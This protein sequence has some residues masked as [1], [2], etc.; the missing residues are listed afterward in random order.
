MSGYSEILKMVSKWQQELTEQ[1]TDG[2][3]NDILHQLIY[4]ERVKF[5]PFLPTLFSTRHPTSYMDRLYA[6][7]T[8][9]GLTGEEQRDLLRFA[10]QIAFFSFDDF[11]VLF[12]SAFTGPISRWCIDQSNIKL[13][14]ADWP[15]R[16]Y[17]ERN[18]KTWFCPVTDSLLI[19]VFHHVNE[20][21]DKN[22]R[23]AFRE[24]K[25][26]GDERPEPD[27]NKIKKHIYD[28][29][30][31]R[32]VL[33]EDFV[34]TGKQTF[35]AVQWAVDTLDIPVLFCPM[36]IGPEGASRYRQLEMETDMKASAGSPEKFRFSPIFTLDSDCF[37]W[38]K[39]ASVS[40]LFQRISSLAE[41]IH[42]DL[43]AS[44][45]HC[46]EGPFGFR[47]EISTL[48]GAAAVMFS[49]TPNNAL[50]LLWHD[51]EGRW[52]SLFP[53]VARQPL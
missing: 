2:D 10:Y 38:N 34:G 4:L 18:Q 13:N 22:Y 9:P 35:K 16:I 39:N 47:R 36:V 37:V 50:P 14:D 49:N 48:A 21:T 33:L 46:K 20:I 40:E 44:Q 30:Y 8:N 51:A 24:L 11:T 31:K 5:Q 25:R 28:K 29:G 41:K 15:E 7:L 17:E 32:L 12:Q 42:Q 43:E 26:F 45:K 6:W 52:K 27:K 19:S 23:P 3:F 1:N 53:R